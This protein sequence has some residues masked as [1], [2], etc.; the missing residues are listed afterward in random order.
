MPTETDNHEVNSRNPEQSACYRPE[1]WPVD[2]Y[3]CIAGSI[4][5]MAETLH[6]AFTGSVESH[7]SRL[8]LYARC[9]RW[10]LDNWKVP[11][12][13]FDVYVRML[14]GRALVEYKQ[15]VAYT[16]KQENA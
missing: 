14:C 15:H 12:C 5:T 13:E 3:G 9:I 8:E 10:A 4:L 11:E 7:D 16:N 6:G 2:K 1:W